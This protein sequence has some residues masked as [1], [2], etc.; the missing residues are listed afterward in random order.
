MPYV[1]RMMPLFE[2]MG[3]P[4]SLKIP[5]HARA[6]M[7]SSYEVQEK[8]TAKFNFDTEFPAPPDQSRF[9]DISVWDAGI[10]DESVWNSE[11]GSVVQ[12]NWRSVGGSG[13]D[14]SLALQITSGEVSPSDVEL[15][16]LDV[17][18]ETAGVVT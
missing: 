3:A 15:V 13:H 5:R 10:W 1:G 7:R 16:R 2:D 17:T 8:L 4:G 9:T 14:A 18:F 11:R 6:I 12:A